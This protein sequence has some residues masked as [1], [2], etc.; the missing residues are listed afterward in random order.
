MGA[1]YNLDIGTAPKF[2]PPR[3]APTTGAYAMIRFAC[4]TCSAIM[5][6]VPE[7]AGVKIHCLKCGQ[8]LQ[9]PELAHGK[10]VLGKLLS[11]SDSGPEQAP[12]P[13]AQPVSPATHARCAPAPAKQSLS[14]LPPGLAQPLHSVVT[15]LLARPTVAFGAGITACLIVGLV[16]FALWPSG[17]SSSKSS[18]QTLPMTTAQFR[19]KVMTFE[20]AFPDNGHW[21][22]VNGRGGRNGFVGPSPIF[23]PGM[24]QPDEHQYN[25]VAL[26]KKSDF[27][28]TFGQ[29]HMITRT[30]R[31]LIWSWTCLDGT[32][33]VIFDTFNE[34]AVQLWFVG[35]DE[36]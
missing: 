5:E 26:F 27:V 22:G 3:T 31:I 29:P 18:P 4:P 20:G 19:E 14:G 2:V 32:V 25:T 1:E 28:G 17:K 30:G 13:E 9:I 10:T 36:S 16:I 7:K 8:R 15:K 6:A 11:A 24:P 12:Y 21:N 33:E 35:I 23:Q 34:N